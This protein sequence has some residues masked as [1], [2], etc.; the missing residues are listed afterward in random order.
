MDCATRPGD[1][2]K[3]NCELHLELLV[4]ILQELHVLDAGCGTG[5]YAESLI[6]SGVAK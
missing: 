3:L 4:W 6:K 1:L 2:A 5:Q